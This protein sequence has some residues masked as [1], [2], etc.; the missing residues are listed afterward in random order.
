MVRKESLA[1]FLD[2]GR[3]KIQVTDEE[4]DEAK[5]RRRLLAASARRAFPGS[6]TYFN[7]SVAHDDANTPLTDVDLGVVLTKKDAE[8]YGPGKKGALPLMEIVRDVIHED[9]DT[10]FR[11]LTVEIVGRRRAV[12]VRFGDPVT[13]GQDDFTADVMTALPHPSG[14]GLYIPNTKIADQWDRA[15]PI[16]HTRMVLQAITDTKVV[17]ARTVRL[18]KHWNCTHSKPMCSWNIKALGLGCLDEPMPLINALQV[19]F[20]YAADEIDKGPTPDPAHV[21]GPIPLNM[22][23]REVHERLCTARDYVDL[24]IEHEAAGRPL[25]AQHALHQVLPELVPDADATQEEAARLVST[26]RSGGTAATGLGL[27]VGLVTPTRAW[28]N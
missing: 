7:G 27:A 1:Q 18:L 13:Q 16:T 2:E 12:L 9:L 22:T 20:T 10:E 21:A 5:R 11:K 3:R 24:A 23:R 6:T 17:F 14:R 19:F 28:G 8:P 25:S 4:L 26:V 15:D